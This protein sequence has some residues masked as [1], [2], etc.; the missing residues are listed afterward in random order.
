MSGSA[1]GRPRALSLRLRLT[2]LWTGVGLVLVT[3]FELLTLAVVSVELHRTVD[4]SMA[5]EARSYERAVAGSGDIVQLENAARDWLARDQQPGS[6][7]A[8]VYVIDFADGSRVTNTVD[9]RLQA[10]IATARAPVREPVTVAGPQGDLRVGAVPILLDGR[11]AGEFRVAMPLADVEAAPTDLLPPML[12]VGAGLVLL[13]ALLAFVLVGRALRRLR[14][15]TETAAGIS[16]CHMHRR[17]GYVGPRDE[18]GRLAQTFDDMLTRLEEGFAQ[19]QS[20]YSLASHELRTPLT[21]VRGHLEVLRRSRTPSPSEVH[22][23]LDIALEE[24]GR[25]TEEVNDMLLLGRMLLGQTG[26]LEPIDARDVIRDVGRRTQSIAR[27]QWRLDLDGPVLVAA[28]REQLGRALLNLVANAV[29]HTGDGDSIALGC[30]RM[31]GWAMLRVADTGR[32]I[33]EHDLPRI[34]EPWYRGGGAKGGNGGLGL[35]IVREVVRA[36][37]GEVTVRSAPETGTSF[38]IRLP[39]RQEPAG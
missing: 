33:A 5:L 34:F 22:E 28:D 15:I 39:L 26:P 14:A 16:D 2:L 37:D 19:R 38:V 20:F 24:L 12:L 10:A 27:R 3:A 29:R 1:D 21:I 31:D 4:D 30:A 11:P 25:V 35:T 7:A 8:A 23:T 9:V 13:G 18:V 17:I 6:G 32:G 36:H